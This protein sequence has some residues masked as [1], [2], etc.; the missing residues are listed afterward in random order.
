MPTGRA[1]HWEVLLRARAIGFFFFSFFLF[2][3]F[4]SF[5]L[6]TQTYVMAAAQ[7]GNH[8][9]KRESYG[10]A[11]IVDPWGKVVANCETESPSLGITELG[12]LLVSL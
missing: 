4:V 9:E 10:H 7:V 3:I 6:E 1:G 5:S 8:S 2:F 12:S 11:M